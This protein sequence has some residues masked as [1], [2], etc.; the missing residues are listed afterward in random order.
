MESE[1][2]TRQAIV[3][4]C[5]KMNATGIN[6]GTSGNISVRFGD[7][8]LITPTSLDYDEM[9]ADDI[10]FINMDGTHEE[11]KK[12][13]SEWRFHRDII[14]ARDDINAVV[15]A[16]PHFSTTLSIMDRDIPAVHYMIAA[17][18]GPRIHCAEY[19]TF[20]TAELSANALAALGDRAACLLSHHGVIVGGPNLPKAMWLSVELEVLARQY[21]ECLR[22]GDPQVLSDEEIARVQEKMAGGYGA[23]EE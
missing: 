5:R 9:T 3:G 16:H 12:P 19:A 22:L 4:A 21:V 15:H 18:G 13:S 11:N 6:Q 20:G 2:S 1:L 8:L 17:F 23:S 10:V 7:G 14:A